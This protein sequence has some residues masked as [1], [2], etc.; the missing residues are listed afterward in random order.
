M[1]TRTLACWR[2]NRARAYTGVPTS[3]KTRGIH[4][5]FA[6]EKNVDKQK[7]D[8]SGE[9][10]GGGRCILSPSRADDGAVEE[11]F[12]LK[13]KTV[14]LSCGQ[15]IVSL[16]LFSVYLY[17]LHLARLMAVLASTF[18]SCMYVCIC[19]C[20]CAC[21]CV[22]VCLSVCRS[23]GLS[24]FRLVGWSICLCACA[25][26]RVCLGVYVCARVRIHAC[27]RAYVGVS[28]CLVVCLHMRVSTCIC[29]YAS[30]IVAVRERVCAGMHI[31]WHTYPPTHAPPHLHTCTHAHMYTLTNSQTHTRTLSHTHT[32]TYTN[33]HSRTK[34]L[35]H[36]PTQRICMH[37]CVYVRVRVYAHMR[38]YTQKQLRAH[39]L[40]YTLVCMS[41]MQPTERISKNRDDPEYHEKHPWQKATAKTLD[42]ALTATFTP[43]R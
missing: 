17:Y 26:M 25:R 42:N 5:D 20:L 1:Y 27:V 18:H 32:H 16:Y 40:K 12:Y 9:S 15:Q 19:A 31:S 4:N 28:D 43:P 13:G 39:T 24:V 35:T 8:S 38:A 10:R 3:G 30:L 21:M 36:S 11:E 2:T 22:C 7:E 23:V 29:V 34:S 14:V 41:I 6:V 33:T 37:V